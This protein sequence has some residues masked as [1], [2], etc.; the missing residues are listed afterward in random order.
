MVRIIISGNGTNGQGAAYEHG[1]SATEPGSFQGAMLQWAPLPF[2]LSISAP[3]ASGTLEATSLRV[4]AYSPLDATYD[5]I[6]AGQ[7]YA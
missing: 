5:A 2:N 7:T 6:E 4:N 1:Y 3:P